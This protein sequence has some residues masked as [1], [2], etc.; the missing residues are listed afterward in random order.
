MTPSATLVIEDVPLV[1]FCARC[2][3]EVAVPSVQ[4]LRCPACGTPLEKIV[5]GREMDVVAVEIE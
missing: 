2:G 3:D 1:A 4:D 5:R